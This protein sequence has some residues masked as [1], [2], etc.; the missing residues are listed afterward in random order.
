GRADR[1]RGGGTS[2]GGLAVAR[3]WPVGGV[4]PARE[5][6]RARHGVARPHASRGGA[7]SGGADAGCGAPA[8]GGSRDRERWLARG[9]RDGGREGMAHARGLTVVLVLTLAGAAGAA[10]PCEE[11]RGQTGL[12]VAVE[13]SGEVVIG[14]IDAESTAAASGVVVGDAIVQVNGVLPRT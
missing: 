9:P 3:R 11:G 8:R 1:R 4:D 13:S 12:G 7:P 2:R 5:R 10:G 6:H 14:A